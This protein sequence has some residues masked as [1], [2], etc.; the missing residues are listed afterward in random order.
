MHSDQV[1]NIKSGGSE[2]PDRG[3]APAQ[4]SAAVDEASGEAGSIWPAVVATMRAAVAILILTTLITGVAYPLA[5]TGVARALFPAQADG[6]LV[7]RGGRVLGSTLI[8]QSFTDA[9]HFWGRPSATTP[10]AYN[11]AASSGSNLGPNNPALKEAVRARV[12]ALRAADPTNRQPIPVDLLTASA[13][14]LDPDIS[15]A[16]A[17]YQVARVA[18][19]RGK[20]AAAV[21]ALVDQART[22]RQFGV[23]GEP[24]VNVLALNLAL[25]A[26]FPARSNVGAGVR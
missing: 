12:L 24:R 8:G 19:L 17:R 13:S 10:A 18:R 26:R 20:P 6:S 9:N 2:P 5:M 14:G 21:S 11:A 25:D 15:V 4:T 23:L 7:K 22:G 3:S 16:A 1:T